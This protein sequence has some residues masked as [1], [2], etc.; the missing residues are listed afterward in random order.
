MFGNILKII[1]TF[2]CGYLVGMLLGGALGVLIGALP[3]LF[4]SEIAAI[5]ILISILLMM[6]S[7]GSLG[8]VEIRIFNK[9]FDTNDRPW[10]GMVIGAIFGLVFGI[11]GYGVL[12]TAGSEA[13]LQYY[14]PVSLIYS[15]AVG[16]R[17]GE[18]IFSIF[19]TVQMILKLVRSSKVEPLPVR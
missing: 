10:L 2:I 9:L 7:G 3:S 8:Y 1:A 19:A 18:V 14:S 5:S 6:I 17:I 15:G 13:F 16:S 11:F 4:F 12:D